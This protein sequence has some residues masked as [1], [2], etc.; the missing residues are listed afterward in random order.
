[1]LAIPA[2]MLGAN[3]IS[4]LERLTLLKAH[5]A[6]K[7][8]PSGVTNI[9]PPHVVERD[10]RQRIR[11]S[12]SRMTPEAQRRKANARQHSNSPAT[13]KIVLEAIN[14]PGRS[15]ASLPDGTVLVGSS[16]QPFLDAARV[17]IAAGYDPDSWLEGWRPGATAFALR[18]RL[19]IAAGLTVDET[20]T[21]F[22]K[23]KPFSSSAVASSIDHSEIPA[24]T[25]A[26]A[27]S[28]LQQ[29]Q[30]EQQSKKKSEPEPGAARPASSVA[31]ECTDRIPAN[32]DNG[33][34]KAQPS[35]NVPPTSGIGRGFKY[36]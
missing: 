1:V 33:T 10:E 4:D 9:P 8:L 16:R 2:E 21:V 18:A 35:P 15:S 3:S 26:A 22:A 14:R 36:P 30:L 5:N 24:T 28:A 11:S 32:F 29:P 12:T 7:G 19:G 31:D 6:A 34:P 23:W 13:I 25:L 20:K 27:H 17:L